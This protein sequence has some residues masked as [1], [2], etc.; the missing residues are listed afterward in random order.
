LNFSAF[1]SS[2]AIDIDLDV[3]RRARWFAGLP[4]ELQQRIVSDSVVRNVA[5]GSCLFR[6][7]E[8]ARGLFG[9]LGGRTRHLCTTTD[10]SDVLMHVGAPGV[11]TGEYAVVSR[12]PAMSSVVA[13]APC[14]V[15]FLAV[16]RWQQ[17]IDEQPQWMRHFAELVAE[18]Y[19]LA[20][21]MDADAQALAPEAWLHS[22]LWAMVEVERG[23]TARARPSR[24][25]LSQAQLATMIGVSRQTLSLQLG[26]LQAQGKLHVGYRCIELLG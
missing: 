6:Q 7:G 22:R 16:G 23:P 14:R 5:R 10:G 3:L 15:L 4:A 19:A 18:R 9:L 2:G 8:P 25:T 17:M 26:R 12:Q 24:L 1:T 13:D 20:F 21:R 11:W